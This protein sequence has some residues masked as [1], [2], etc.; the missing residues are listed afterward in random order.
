[1]AKVIDTRVDG[2]GLKYTAYDTKLVDY[3]KAPTTGIDPD[4][5]FK[6]G[7]PKTLEK[8]GEV[9]YFGEEFKE[10]AEKLGKARQ[11]AYRRRQTNEY[12]R[13]G[14]SAPGDRVSEATSGVRIGQLRGEGFTQAQQAE[15][16]AGRQ[17][18]IAQARFEAPDPSATMT[19]FNPTANLRTAAKAFRS[20]AGTA[21]EGLQSF[22][23][24]KDSGG[25]G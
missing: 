16:Q 20:L 2:R 5:K 11:E 18:A 10:E 6:I 13:T 8:P 4:K 23:D 1:M 12:I 7:K 24:K 9:T 22:R 14:A 21:A 19:N 3:A 17:Q 25:L 15:K